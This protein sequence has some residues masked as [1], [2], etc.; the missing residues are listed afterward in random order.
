MTRRIFQEPELKAQKDKAIEAWEAIFQAMDQRIEAADVE[1]AVLV[2]AWGCLD[3]H[4][5]RD[6][7]LMPAGEG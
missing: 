6:A 4:R 7:L 3:L 1:S 5:T 2:L